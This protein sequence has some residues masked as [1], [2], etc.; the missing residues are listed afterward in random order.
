MTN[1][2]EQIIHGMKLACFNIRKTLKECNDKNNI[3]NN[4]CRA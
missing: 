2:L 1:V 3:T 4:D